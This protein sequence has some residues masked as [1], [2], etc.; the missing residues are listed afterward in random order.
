MLAKEPVVRLL[1]K[2]RNTGAGR[3]H[4]YQRARHCVDRC[5]FFYTL[6]FILPADKFLNRTFG[7]DLLLMGIRHLVDIIGHRIAQ[8]AEDLNV[9]SAVIFGGIKSYVGG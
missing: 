7:K 5:I 2:L 3:P 9:V 6:K 8:S 1:E 4:Q